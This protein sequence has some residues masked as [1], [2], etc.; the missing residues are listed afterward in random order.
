VYTIFSHSEPRHQLSCP[1][2]SASTVSRS[3]VWEASTTFLA[4]P[5]PHAARLRRKAPPSRTH[6]SNPRR[7]CLRHCEAPGAKLYM[8]LWVQMHPRQNKKLSANYHF[9]TMYAP[10]RQKLMHPQ[11]QR[12]KVERQKKF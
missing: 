12:T 1:S 5:P 8:W 3:T 2:D 4:H 9:F 7:F 11:I 10:P 6:P